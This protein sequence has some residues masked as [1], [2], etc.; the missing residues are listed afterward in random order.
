MPDFPQFRVTS[1]GLWYRVE[2]RA[3][4]TWLWVN[5]ATVDCYSNIPGRF[6][7]YDEALKT[8]EFLRDGNDPFTFVEVKPVEITVSRR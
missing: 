8:C 1:N 3:D 2:Y 5:A 6:K 7:I 4:I